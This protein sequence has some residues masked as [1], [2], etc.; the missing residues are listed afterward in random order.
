MWE[1]VSILQG[2]LEGAGVSLQVAAPLVVMV[3]I[4]A[5]TIKRVWTGIVFRRNMSECLVRIAL[6]IT[7]VEG[8][9]SLRIIACSQEDYERLFLSDI[10]KVVEEYAP[11]W[12]KHRY[13]REV[14]KATFLTG[15]LRK[16]TSAGYNL[17]SIQVSV[18]E[19]MREC[20]PFHIIWG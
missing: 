5:I 7:G 14:S 3:A 16:H 2:I 4:V 15:A 1:A 11:V 20:F 6:G 12:K 10:Q 8:G 9:P 17:K 13:L 19:A 18:K